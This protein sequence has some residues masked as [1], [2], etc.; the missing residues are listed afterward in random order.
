M[1]QFYFV[2]FANLEFI[3]LVKHYKLLTE[4]AYQKLAIAEGTLTIK[5]EVH[6]TYAGE[7]LKVPFE[8]ILTCKIENQ[9]DTQHISVTNA[10]LN[11]IGSILYGYQNLGEISFKDA[12]SGAKIWKLLDKT[13]P[14]IIDP[15]I[16]D[17]LI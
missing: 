12:S 16:V 4:D 11:H 15:T 3:M 6:V 8:E 14:A 17:Y 2:L 13:K 10:C 1:H 7:T 5:I 9:P